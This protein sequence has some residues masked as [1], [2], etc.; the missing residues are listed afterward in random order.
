MKINCTK[1]QSI[2]AN[3]KMTKMLDYLTKILT[4]NIIK[5]TSKTIS[6]TGETNETQPQQIN[7][8]LRKIMEILK[9]SIKE[10]KISV[11]YWEIYICFSFLFPDKQLLRSLGSL[12]Y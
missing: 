7:T 9:N 6:N 4:R 1:K 2:D 10:V 5:K 12:K 3:T 11:D 8:N